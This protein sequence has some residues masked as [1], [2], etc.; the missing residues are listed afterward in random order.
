MS[1]WPESEE[2]RAVHALPRAWVEC[3]A[4]KALAGWR[5]RRLET[6][7]GW[8]RAKDISGER[9]TTNYIWVAERDGLRYTGR[10]LLTLLGTM[11][12]L[13]AD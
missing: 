6:I 7:T 10:T 8:E 2:E 1:N 11:D 12:E 4:M 5:F 3:M 13:G 9:W